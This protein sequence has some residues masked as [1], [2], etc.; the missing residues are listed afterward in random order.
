M[1]SNTPQR[2]P[3]SPGKLK[4]IGVALLAVSAFMYISIILKT[5]QLG[6]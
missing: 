2:P 6:P 5:D 3:V 4:W 1:S